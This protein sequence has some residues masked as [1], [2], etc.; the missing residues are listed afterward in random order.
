MKSYEQAIT[1]AGKYLAFTKL[2][3]AFTD[4]ELQCITYGQSTTIAAIYDEDEEMT[5][6]K[7]WCEMQGLTANDFAIA[8][9]Y[10]EYY[11]KHVEF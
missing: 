2:S 11:A 1:E 8:E 3:N 5:S 9:W 7:I 6:R 4:G 10:D